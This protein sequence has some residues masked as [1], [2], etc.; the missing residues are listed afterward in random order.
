MIQKWMYSL[1][2]KV[3]WN[4]WDMIKIHLIMIN[5]ENIFTMYF[6]DIL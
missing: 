4:F 6:H 3:N 2:T 5:N 1:R